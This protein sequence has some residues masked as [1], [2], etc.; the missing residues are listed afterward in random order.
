MSLPKV[1]IQIVHI[2]LMR[3]SQ[4]LIMLSMHLTSSA[5]I[6]TCRFLNFFNLLNLCT[7]F[8][9][10]GANNMYIH[11]ELSCRCV[12]VINWGF[13]DMQ[14]VLLKLDYDIEQIGHLSY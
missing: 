5:F 7:V 6:V 12:C 3:E 10:R 4:G 9:Y 11:P 2:I 14:T 1:D 13:K 8:N